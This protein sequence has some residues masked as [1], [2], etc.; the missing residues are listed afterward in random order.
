[1]KK[2]ISTICACIMLFSTGFGVFAQEKTELPLIMMPFHNALGVDDINEISHGTIVQGKIKAADIEAEDLQKWL[3]AYWNFSCDL[4][5]MPMVEISNYDCYVKL[6][7]KDETKSYTVYPWGVA[8]GR[9]GE[10]VEYNGRLAQNYVWYMPYIGNA[11]NALYTASS[12]LE[13]KYFDKT[14]EKYTGTEREVA[15]KDIF[16]LPENNLLDTS[17][18]S[19]WAV[20]EIK[21]AAAL[22]LLTYE[23]TD[24][25]K[26]DITRLEFAKLAFRFIATDAEPLSDS[27]KGAWAA[28]DSI[29]DQNNLRQDYNSAEFTDCSYDEVKFLAGVGIINGMGDG[30]FMPE[31][32]LTREQAATILFKMA[33]FLGENVHFRL[34][35]KEYFYDE[36]TVSDWALTAVKVMNELGVMNGIDNMIFSP[37]GTYTV[38]QAVATMVRLFD[39]VGKTYTYETPLGE[40]VSDADCSSWVNFAKEGTGYVTLVKGSENFIINQPVEVFT[41]QTTTVNIS[42]DSFAEIFGGTWEL[43][44]DKLKFT[45]DISKGIDIIP[46]GDAQSNII[47]NGGTVDVITFDN[48]NTILVNDMKMPIQSKYGR[49]TS[50]GRVLMYNGNLYIPVQVV[51]DILGYEFA[52]II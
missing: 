12:E 43:L 33:N 39:Y 20:P 29:I 17:N 3:D 24:K 8:V 9:L 5:I 36:N 2:V 31:G 45:Y 28:V 37:Q 32:K 7:N 52:G 10:P 41:N 23:L 19:E 1:M 11:R 49:K 46:R 42:L 48:I 13:H 30:T 6:W 22:N 50:Q 40:V 34:D 21:K 38:Q 27:R 44:E 16:E 14:Y 18:A 47:I 25:F 51:A 15:D 35:E 4:V 26:E